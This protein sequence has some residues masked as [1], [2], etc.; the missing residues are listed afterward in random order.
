[1][2]EFVKKRVIKAGLV[3]G[4]LILT[5]IAALYIY[6]EMRKEGIVIDI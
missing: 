5:K 3:T 4:G 1:M 6:K 2:K